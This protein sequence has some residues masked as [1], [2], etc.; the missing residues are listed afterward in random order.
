MMSPSFNKNL[1]IPLRLTFPFQFILFF[2]VKGNINL[3]AQ[4]MIDAKG[5]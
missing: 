5:N 4:K 3:T 1:L 2:E